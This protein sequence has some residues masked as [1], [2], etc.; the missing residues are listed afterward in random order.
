MTRTPARA[1]RRK[2]RHETK[3]E[4]RTHLERLIRN[5]ASRSRLEIYKCK[6]CD[7]YHVGH[8]LGSGSRRR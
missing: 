7:H 4:A 2:M 5:G 1:C 8:K 6:F 3:D